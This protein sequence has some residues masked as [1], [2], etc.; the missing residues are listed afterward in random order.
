MRS[1]PVAVGG[2]VAES[3]IQVRSAVGAL[4]RI[5]GQTREHQL[6]EQT[7]HAAVLDDVDVVL[8]GTGG[9][10][11]ALERLAQEELR[12]LEA[13]VGL[14]RGARWLLVCFSFMAVGFVEDTTAT[15]RR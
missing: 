15:V 12:P 8:G 5:L 14:G 9:V 13:V 1:A 10:P 7:R 4:L 3:A 11:Q 6:V 2:Y